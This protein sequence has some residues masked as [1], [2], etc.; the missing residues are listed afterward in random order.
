MKRV[1]LVWLLI[2]LLNLSSSTIFRPKIVS[3]PHFPSLI[4]N[5][6]V[7]GYEI[8]DRYF[9]VRIVTRWRRELIC[10]GTIINPHFIITAARCFENLDPSSAVIEAGDFHR[11]P[12]IAR[13][14]R[15][16]WVTEAPGPLQVKNGNNVALVQLRRPI[17]QFHQVMSVCLYDYEH[18]TSLG[19]C[20]MGSSSGIN[21]SPLTTIREIELKEN[22]L[23]KPFSPFVTERRKMCREN[24]VCTTRIT[25]G[26][27]SCFGDEGNPLYA[28]NPCRNESGIPFCLYG[29]ATEYHSKRK[30]NGSDKC[31]GGSQFA[32]VSY[33]YDWIDWMLWESPPFQD[34]CCV[35]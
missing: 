35:S 9:Y 6:L 4:Q 33:F 30:D 12:P 15:I 18:G 17:E 8:E 21:N 11:E 31:D 2:L 32:R 27:N 23:D 1:S 5:N 25:P 10:G 7:N 22:K 26:G 13:Y 28:W 14:H 29:V 3:E 19:T 16:A 24:L 20:G 34:T